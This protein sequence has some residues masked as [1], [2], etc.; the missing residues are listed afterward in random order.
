LPELRGT[1]DTSGPAELI[2]KVYDGSQFVTCDA[3]TKDARLY[4]RIAIDVDDHGRQTLD[5]PPTSHRGLRQFV[6]NHT[7]ERVCI[8]TEPAGRGFVLRFQIDGGR[9]F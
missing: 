6:D 9:P 2:Y 7:D 5:V 1:I 4:V 3:K 8:T